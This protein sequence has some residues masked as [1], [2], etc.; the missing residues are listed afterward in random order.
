MKLIKARVLRGFCIGSGHD[1]FPGDEIKMT[2][3]EFRLR[4]AQQRVM[5]IPEEEV[6]LKAE[7]QTEIPAEEPDYRRKK[8]D[9]KGGTA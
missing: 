8:S 4:Q 9:K 6:K 2:E 5:E 3:A 7:P 1:L